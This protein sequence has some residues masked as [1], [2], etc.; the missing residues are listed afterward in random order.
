[1]QGDQSYKLVI[2]PSFNQEKVGQAIQK[3]I[4][5][6]VKISARMGDKT[7]KRPGVDKVY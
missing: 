5:Y 2:W 4:S 6:L 3:A 1:M 7:Q